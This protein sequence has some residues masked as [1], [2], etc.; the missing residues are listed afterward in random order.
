VPEQSLNYAQVGPKLEQV[1][2]EGVSKH[3]RRDGLGDPCL[4]GRLFEGS[5][6]GLRR[7]HG[8]RTAA[9]KKKLARRSNGAP[10][11]AQREQ[12]ALTEHYITIAPAFA[13]TNVDQSALAIDVADAQ[14]TDL[15]HAL[16]RH[17]SRAR[18]VSPICMLVLL[19]ALV[20]L[21]EFAALAERG[22]AA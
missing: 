4:N 10:V 12:H 2:R 14:V 16:S 19:P 8:P 1:R 13:I 22:A 6:D 3:M 17:T 11:R 7:D 18:P 21:A 5:T 15:A 20:L 9:G